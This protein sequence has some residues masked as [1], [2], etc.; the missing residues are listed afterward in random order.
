[1]AAENNADKHLVHCCF[2]LSKQMLLQHFTKHI[3]RW[4]MKNQK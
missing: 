3:Q 2:K 1:M 4:Y